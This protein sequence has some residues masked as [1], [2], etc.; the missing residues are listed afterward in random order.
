MSAAAVAVNALCSCSPSHRVYARSYTLSYDAVAYVQFAPLAKRIL[1][2]DLEQRDEIDCLVKGLAFLT[3]YVS[4][5]A[6]TF[7]G[8]YVPPA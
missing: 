7:H 8:K 6:Y 1:G 3:G 5:E 2:I 4:S